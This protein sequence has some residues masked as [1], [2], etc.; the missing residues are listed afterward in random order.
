MAFRSGETAVVG[1]EDDDRFLGQPVLVQGGDQSADRR[2]ELIQHR[3][4]DRVVLNEAHLIRPLLAPSVGRSLLRLFLPFRDQVGACA[5]GHMRCVVRQ[6]GIEVLI[7]VRFDELYRR[8]RDAVGVLGVVLR[9]CLVPL[10]PGVA[11]LIVREALISRHE[12][13][14]AQVPFAGE[15]R[16]VTRVSQGFG[17]RHFL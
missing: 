11:A 1:H 10:R 5:D 8:V 14:A 2:I 7:L 15:K 3:G 12:S 16:L 17:N 13:A 9:L 4:I 6:V